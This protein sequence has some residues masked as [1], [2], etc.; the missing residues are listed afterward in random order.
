MRLGLRSDNLI[1]WLAL[2]L[3]LVPTPAAEV[4]AGMALSGVLIAATESGLTARL[5]VAPA[6]LE[7]LTAELGLDPTALGLVLDFLLASGHV[8]QRGS[9]YQLSRRSRRWLD[10][11]SDLSVAH[12]VAGNADYWQWWS[13]LT[14]VTRSG[15]PVSH[16]DAEPDSAYW[17]RY[18]TGQ[19]ELARLSAAEVARRVHVPAGARTMLDLGG[20][21][22]W[23]SAAICRRHPQLNATVLDLPGSARVG[24]EIITRAGL[25]DRVVHR[26]GD[27][28]TAEL[29][30]PYDVVLCFNLIHH[31]GLAQVRAVLSKIRGV[32]APSGSLAILDAFASRSRRRSTSASY[33]GLFMYLSSGAAVYTPDELHG[34]LAAAGFEAPRRTPIRRIPGLGL[35][36]AHARP[37]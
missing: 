2:R 8:R 12:F 19:L 17:R 10:P 14:E 23:Y 31:L 34:W 33:L 18:I 21:H 7:Q 37:A 25:T 22:G 3:G 1:E 20:G 24:R 6:T 35:Y 9:R 36:Q 27:A 11:D 28:L 32:L 30:G 5:A 15:S 4:W 29:G 26:D 16:H 13:G